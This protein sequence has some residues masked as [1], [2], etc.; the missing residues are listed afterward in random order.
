MVERDRQINKDKIKCWKIKT[1]KY[2]KIILNTKIPNEKS[3]FIL[4][5]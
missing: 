1:D 2:V 3:N 4:V 5:N